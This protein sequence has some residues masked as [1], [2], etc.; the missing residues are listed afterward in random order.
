MKNKDEEKNKTYR[1]ESLKQEIN[2]PYIRL[3][4]PKE[5]TLITTKFNKKENVLAVAWHMP[6]SFK[7]FLYVI[8][9]AK[10]RYSYLLIKRSKVFC[11][12][13]VPASLKRKV[14]YCGT[15]SGK[16]HD[17]FKEASLKKRP[18]KYINCSYLAD[19][20]AWLECEVINEV[21]TGDHVLFIGKVLY[22]AK[23]KEAKRLYHVEL[24]QFVQI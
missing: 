16:T 15:C 14:L 23:Q 5:T 19:A 3:H 24:D 22:A 11:V 8:S 18:C 20:L 12:N 1:K 13:F 17:K 6:C 7:P 4:G 2:Q 10:S 21:E 9:I